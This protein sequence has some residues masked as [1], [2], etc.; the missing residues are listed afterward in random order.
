MD[1][2][3]RPHCIA[4]TAANDG[5]SSENDYH[6]HDKVGIP[7]NLFRQ[8]RFSSDGTTI[9]TLKANR[10]FQSF[11][12]PVDLLE[13]T[14]QPHTLSPTCTIKC[15]DAIQSYA[16]YPSFNLQDPST[17]VFL[18]A[19]TDLPITLQNAIYADTVHAKYKL[20][21]PTTEVFIAPTSLAWTRQGDR[22]VA[23][24]NSQISVFDAHR[25]DAGPVVTSKAARNRKQRQLG[26]YSLG[27]TGLVMAMSINGEGMLAAGTGERQVALYAN[28]GSGE[29]TTTF[30]LKTHR[31]VEKPSS[32]IQGTG[33][34]SLA[35]SPCSTYLLI[36][37]RQS[38]EIQ[39]FD[40][41]HTMRRISF[42]TGRKALTTQKLDMSVIPAADGCEVWAGGTDGCVRLWRD[43]G[44]VEGGHAPDESF[45]V[46]HDAVASTSWH[47]EGAVLAT[48]AGRDDRY[49]SA[50]RET[51]DN[52]GASEPRDD[53]LKIWV[54]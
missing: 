35:W 44:V 26:G 47:P 29:C 25:S 37:Q 53:S 11:V 3:L 23:G 21:N 34:T 9:L 30:S 54:V 38:D 19:T 50:D 31:S 16:L 20:I 2:L 24:S 14:E 18:S 28:E 13:E 27:C 45:K 36:A 5:S 33:I 43:P 32:S 22:F 6:A 17:T 15:P 4:S 10:S 48:C 42:L 46:H 39:I 7:P 40:V 51:N 8:A 52:D 41:R 12:L 1:A 49:H